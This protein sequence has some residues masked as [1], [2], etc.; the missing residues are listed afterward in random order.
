[1]SPHFSCCKIPTSSEWPT[2]LPPL[3]PHGLC[4]YCVL[5][6]TLLQP[7]GSPALSACYY[8]ALSLECSSLTWVTSYAPST[9]SSAQWGLP[10]RSILGQK[11]PPHPRALH[12]SFPA[13]PFPEAFITVQGTLSH[14]C[15]SLFVVCSHSA[16]SAGQDFCLLVPGCTSEPRVAPGTWQSSL[17]SCSVVSNCLRSH[18]LQ[19]ARLSCPSLSP[20]L[21]KLIEQRSPLSQWCHPTISSSVAPFSSCH[22]SFPES[23]SFPVSHM[24]DLQWIFAGWMSDYMHVHGAVGTGRNYHKGLA[25]MSERFQSQGFSSDPGALQADGAMMRREESGCFSVRGNSDHIDTR[26]RLPL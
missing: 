25:W 11:P 22:Q 4:E 7:M 3:D 9:L 5:F 13:S 6:I 10:W 19:C 26:V 21:H 20:S 24:V 15:V 17:F 18:G 8:L 14:L 2:G 12:P 16:V 23:G 1:M